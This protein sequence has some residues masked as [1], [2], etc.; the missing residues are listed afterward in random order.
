MSV[1]AILDAVRALPPDDQRLVVE[2]IREEFDPPLT[3]AER[4][5]IEQRLA[6]YYANPDRVTPFEDAFAEIE[7]ELGE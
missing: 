3:E 1:E 5:H 6:T 7:A 2:K 4:K